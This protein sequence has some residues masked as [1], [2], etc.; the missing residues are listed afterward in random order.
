MPSM[1][2]SVANPTYRDLS[3]GLFVLLII[4]LII[5]FYISRKQAK[6]TQYSY[7]E[8]VRIRMDCTQYPYSERITDAI[9]S[10]IV[11]LVGFSIFVLLSDVPTVGIIFGVISLCL[12]GAMFIQPIANLFGYQPFW[13]KIEKSSN[14]V[15][16]GS[17]I[18]NSFDLENLETTQ[19]THEQKQSQSN[20]CPYCGKGL[21]ENAIRC[22]HCNRL[23][24]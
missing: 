15:S 2:S 13:K 18:S 20:S 19:P 8:T 3:V 21:K 12:L 4:G 23:I 11:L 10:F 14:P 9:I 5:Y 1:V 6:K 22:I 16:Q 24:K 17:K 7:L